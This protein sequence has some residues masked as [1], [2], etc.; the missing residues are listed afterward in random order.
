MIFLIEKNCFINFEVIFF[1]KRYLLKPVGT[2]A[3]YKRKI[4]LEVGTREG[5][6]RKST[7][8][9]KIFFQSPLESRMKNNFYVIMSLVFKSQT[10]FFSFKR[11]IFN[12][13]SSNPDI[14]ICITMNN[15][16]ITDG[17]HHPESN[18]SDT[19]KIKTLNKNY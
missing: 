4:Q 1:L 12:S 8:C 5:I 16:D 19:I 15:T 3:E 2:F 11:I 6:F 10:I 7:S 9:I 14:P 18:S 13:S 17:R